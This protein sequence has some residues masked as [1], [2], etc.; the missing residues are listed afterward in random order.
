MRKPTLKP[1]VMAFGAILAAIAMSVS[2]NG[3]SLRQGSTTGSA[4]TGS[5]PGQVLWGYYNTSE[6]VG[7][8]CLISTDPD[9]C[10]VGGAGDNILRLVNPNGSANGNLVG[11]QEQTV[12]AMIYVFDDDEEMGECCGC[13]LSSTRLKTFSVENDLTSDWGLQSGPEGGEHGN[14]AIAIVA[15]APNTV[16]SRFGS[17]LI[18]T[19]GGGRAGQ[20]LGSACC[21]PT[22]APGYSVTTAAN[23]L[24]S[25]T[26]NQIVQFG[27]TTSIEGFTQITEVGLA[28]D[29]GGDPTNLVYLQ[30]QCGALVGNGSGGGVCDCTVLPFSPITTPTPTTS[31]TLTPTAT[32]TATPTPTQTPTATGTATATAT[33]TSTA[34]STSTSTATATSTVTATPTA[35]PTPTA[36]S[37]ATTTATATTTPTATPTTTTSFLTSGTTFSVPADWN[38]NNNSIQ[39][40][41][42]GGGGL[43]RSGAPG[44]GGGAYC[45][46]TN[47]TLT[48]SGSV[49]IQ[50]GAGG[51]AGASGT[52]SWF[53]GTSSTSASCGA[54]GGAGAAGNTGGPGGTTGNSI[55]GATFAGGSGGSTGGTGSASAG[56]GGAAG[57]NGLG[58]NGVSAPSTTPGAGGAGD[59]GMGG[60]G[61]AVGGSA[62]GNGTE[63]Q[64][65]PAFGSGGGGGSGTASVNG[66]QGGNYGG[67]GGGAGHGGG[68][69]GPGLCIVTYTPI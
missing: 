18:N 68:A 1:I 59:A 6:D 37:T 34:T 9:G 43:T 20:C 3:G 48:P 5:L 24:G 57:P 58:V 30:S 64:V 69:G 51:A 46:T 12:C 23:L 32:G 40:I 31:P 29:G 35:T 61:G 19:G 50:I 45:R 13:P 14:G 49:Q 38:D 25:I 22:N 44:G 42:A 2:A 27:P 54:A 15:S 62:G 8:P 53:N 55:G 66:G 11:A 33:P 39:C 63:F 60:T 67:G 47:V 52:A 4:V 56:G 36:T 7:G 21:D 65:S 28:G 26:H 41:G 10:N 17:T 16:G